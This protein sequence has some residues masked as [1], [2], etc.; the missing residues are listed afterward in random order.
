MKKLTLFILLYCCLVTGN[1]FSQDT[2]EPMIVQPPV[3]DTMYEEAEVDES[4]W[5]DTALVSSVTSFSKDSILAYKKQ[6]SFA[7]I[8]NID[9]ILKALQDE[10]LRKKKKERPVEFINPFPIIR[11]LLWALAIAVVV[12]VIYRLFL[13]KNGLFAAPLKN[14]QLEIVEEGLTDETY[15][16]RQLKE[17]IKNGNYRLAIR[18]LYL[19]TLSKL[20]EKNWLQLSPDKTNYQYVKELPKKE[21]KNEFARI[22]LHYEYA[23]YGEFTIN[24]EVFDPLQKEF[25]QFQD[26][27]KRA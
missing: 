4:E 20:A 9:S 24:E 19:Q 6:K 26:K 8:R 15:I 3:V 22:T 2:V 12:F 7:Y 13:G 5:V 16:D 18:F 10:E 11:I 21:L 1:L 27:V 23:W 25:Q 14:K 17:A